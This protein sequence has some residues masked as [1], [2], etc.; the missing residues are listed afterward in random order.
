MSTKNK[1]DR[2]IVITKKG[3]QCTRHAAIYT[4][5]QRTCGMHESL[6]YII[7]PDI[8]QESII[9]PPPRD[10]TLNP[11]GIHECL[12]VG[13]GQPNILGEFVCD[14]HEYI[15]KHVEVAL[16]FEK[17]KFTPYFQKLIKQQD[18]REDDPFYQERVLLDQ[19]I[20][21]ELNAIYILP[22]RPNERGER[23]RSL[24]PY[25]I[26]RC[27]HLDNFS[28]DN[29]WGTFVCEQEN[30]FGYFTCQEH[31]HLEENTKRIIALGDIGNFSRRYQNLLYQEIHDS[32]QNDRFFQERIAQH[33]AMPQVH[34]RQY[35][36]QENSWYPDPQ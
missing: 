35:N 1:M 18:F 26:N 19:E 29:P 24:N 5:L 13:C 8:T 33:Q 11:Y 27:C 28:S 16:A 14:S 17:S 4:H 30:R 2:C 22:P 21:N 32:R 9:H 6:S 10:A 7:R 15:K 34:I 31:S 36:P 3:T 20:R 23:L 25:Y 12:V